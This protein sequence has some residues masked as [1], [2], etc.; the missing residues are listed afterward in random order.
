MNIVQLAGNKSRSRTEKKIRK[1]E[2]E[3][4]LSFLSKNVDILKLLITS[5]LVSSTKFSKQ[6]EKSKQ[7]DTFL[8]LQ[9]PSKCDSPSVLFNKIKVKAE[10]PHPRIPSVANS[11]VKCANGT[12]I[13]SIRVETHTTSVHR[14]LL[15]QK[16]TRSL[17]IMCFARCRGN[18]TYKQWQLFV[19]AE[20]MP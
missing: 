16:Y 7:F 17:F 5:P 15:E 4:V 18:C 11:T 14:K 6:T 3:S 13:I 20:H 12:V 9:V 8:V 2:R 1:R 10:N 19:F